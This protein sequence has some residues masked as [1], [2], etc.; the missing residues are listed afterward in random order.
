MDLVKDSLIKASAFTFLMVLLG[1]LIGLQMDNL[2]Q[3]RVSDELR[4]SNLETETFTVL[5]SYVEGS[6]ENFCELAEL[7]LPDVGERNAEL[8]SS[9]ERFDSGSLTD[10]SEY[11]YL[12]NRYYN[13]QLQ[14]FMLVNDY[15]DRCDGGANTVLYFFSD[16]T[17]SQ[18]QGEVLSEVAKDRDDIYIFSFNKDI[19]DDD[20]F[21][22]SPVLEI[23]LKDYNVTET[24]T[25]VINGDEKIEGFISQGELENEVLP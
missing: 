17:Q 7:R 16:T 19:A 10:K 15:R 21:A 3:D 18:R 5:Q 22:D 1:V 9:L 6:G 25:L 12:R 13:N 2:R 14:L 23:L 24:P 4:Q 8:G 11:E 20:R